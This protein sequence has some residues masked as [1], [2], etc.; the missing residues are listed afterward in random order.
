MNLEKKI[1]DYLI[2]HKKRAKTIEAYLIRYRQFCE[3]LGDITPEAAT[4]E[5]VFE[6]LSFVIKHH[7]STSSAQQARAVLDILFNNI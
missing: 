1:E 5:Q 4:E 2:R 3:F 6:F 7:K